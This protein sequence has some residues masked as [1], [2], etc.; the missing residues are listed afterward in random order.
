MFGGDG[1]IGK[2]ETVHLKGVQCENCHGPRKAHMTNPSIK[3]EKAKVDAC[4]TCHQKDHSPQFEKTH[5]WS[6]IKH[7]LER[8]MNKW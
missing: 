1:F 6:Q 8:E 5:Y 4:V 7:S 3:G 2:K